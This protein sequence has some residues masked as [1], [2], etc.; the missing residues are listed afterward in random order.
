MRNWSTCTAWHSERLNLPRESI[1][2]LII[3][4]FAYLK[5]ASSDIIFSHSHCGVK[6]FYSLDFI[7]TNGVVG[8]C[9]CQPRFQQCLMAPDCLCGNWQWAEDEWEEL[10]TSPSLLRAA[11]PTSRA[12]I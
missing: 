2:C 9:S 8:E 4:S 12:A 7:H 5:I 10:I 3:N 6:S 11:P 1:P